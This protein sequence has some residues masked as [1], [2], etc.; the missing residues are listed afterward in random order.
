MQISYLVCAYVK[1]RAITLKMS[2]RRVSLAQKVTRRFLIGE[3]GTTPD[4]INLSLEGIVR[5]WLR[6][7]M[8]SKLVRW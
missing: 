3:R 5:K 7:R 1:A 6:F 2:L 4:Q 8:E